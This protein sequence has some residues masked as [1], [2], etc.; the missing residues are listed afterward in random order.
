M[1]ANLIKELSCVLY[2]CLREVLVCC[3]YLRIRNNL[4]LG[5]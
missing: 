1:L 5:V 4:S 3:H 2:D